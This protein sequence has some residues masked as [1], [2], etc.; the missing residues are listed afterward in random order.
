MA[1]QGLA[2]KHKAADLL[3]D[4]EKF[5]CPTQT[6][7]NWMLEEIQAAI[8]RRPH[9]SALEPNIIAHFAEEVVDKEVM[10]LA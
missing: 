5:G 8:N 6:G 1:P 10:I 4:W 9:K 7:C 2:Q 3:A